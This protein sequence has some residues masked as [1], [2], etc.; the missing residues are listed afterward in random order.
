MKPFLRLLKK[1]P[2]RL[3]ETNLH[4]QNAIYILMKYAGNAQYTDVHRWVLHI[5]QK[6]IFFKWSI[7]LLV[8]KFNQ[9]KDTNIG[10]LYCFAVLFEG[11][12]ESQI[13]QKTN[14]K[15]QKKNQFQMWPLN[16]ASYCVVFS[17]FGRTRNSSLYQLISSHSS[18]LLFSSPSLRFCT[19][20][21]F[22]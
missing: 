19:C 6:N 13:C 3:S 1:E 20:G 5:F 11:R 17:H 21:I 12:L 10:I 7:P 16:G 14:M 4:M 18:L 2:A 15:N 9:I 22:F 8:K